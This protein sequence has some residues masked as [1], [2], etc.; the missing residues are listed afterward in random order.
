MKLNLK[1]KKMSVAPTPIN[2]EQD[3]IPV[4]KIEYGFIKQTDGKYV[5]ILEVETCEYTNL[6]AEE[7]WTKALAY[8]NV[9]EGTC[10][11]LHVKIK[12]SLED[13]SGFFDNVHNEQADDPNVF[14]QERKKDYLDTVKAF[15]SSSV[16]KQSIYFIFT[17]EGSRKKENEIYEEFD[18]V[19]NEYIEALAKIGCNVVERSYKD[20]DHAVEV[21]YSCLNPKT[22][23]SESIIDRY[24]RIMS[25]YERYNIVHS[26]QK[27]PIVNDLI[28]PKGLDFTA[29]NGYVVIDGM[30]ETFLTLRGNSIPQ[31]LASDFI[32]YLEKYG[33][34]I[35][36]F[37]ERIP[38]SRVMSSMKAGEKS[39]QILS[40]SNE[41][42]PD[43]TK[44]EEKYGYFNTLNY[45]RGALLNEEHYYDTVIVLTFKSESLKAL[46][47][48][49]DTFRNDMGKPPTNTKYRETYCNAEELFLMTLP[50]MYYKPTSEVFKLNSRGF[51]TSSLIS[52]MPFSS[53]DLKDI[54]G[55]IWGIN[56]STSGLYAINTFNRN[57]GFTNPN[58]AFIGGTGA[59][60]SFFQMLLGSRMYLNGHRVFYVCPIKGHEYQWFAK[61]L[62]GTFVSLLPQM[63]CINLF[64][65][66]P[67]VSNR[68][69]NKP[70]PLLTKKI[71]QII[72]FLRMSMPQMTTK[73]QG[74]LN[75]ALMGLY[76]SFGITM[77]NESIFDEN[78]TLKKMPTFSDLKN[79]LANYSELKEVREH[80]ERY[81]SGSWSNLDGQTN[82][83]LSKNCIVINCDENEME[84]EYLAPIMYLAI[85]TLYDIIKTNGN[86]N[87]V[88]NIDEVWKCL[89][90]KSVA[91]QVEKMARVIRGYQGALF[92]AT[93]D[94][95]S[96]MK[97]EIGSTILNLCDT[98]I[99]KR[100]KGSINKDNTEVVIACDA[101]GL[102]RRI[103]V[104]KLVNLSQREAL[105]ITPT[106]QTQINIFSSY[107]ERHIYGTDDKSIARRNYLS[108]KKQWG[109]KTFIVSY[110]DMENMIRK[111]L[112]TVKD[113]E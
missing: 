13:V 1:Q 29:N 104:P 69:V 112:A 77:E 110:E 26:E 15:V 73:E 6:T 57:E 72:T 37:T 54:T 24:N 14:V 4:E 59:G 21:L 47:T 92:V 46:K 70:T 45:I 97:N 95:E 3:F 79:Y 111:N 40:T 90:N 106:Q 52:L 81:I 65:I 48:K 56:E 94:I 51:L 64:E 2:R 102:D 84:K 32:P 34:E 5:K 101:L 98:K 78:K 88:L 42:T 39:K 41:N 53:K 80:I 89:K 86:K 87:D 108:T 31:N 68:Y 99:I 74:Q 91:E 20:N 16:K 60:K 27:N 61:S 10:V 103:Y 25:D 82:V 67:E 105:V 58:M 9:F 30:Y 100:L 7:Q 19:V 33:C 71:A 23:L 76:E 36:I 22:E 55:V 43:T 38:S 93:Q 28:S 75:I 66:R 12:S 83:D 109:D 35:D 17:Y 85:M 50:L 63:D 62:N 96:F 49:V 11:S 113:L 107:S 44:I 8:A 18:L